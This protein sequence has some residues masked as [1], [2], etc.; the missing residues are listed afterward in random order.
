MANEKSLLATIGGAVKSVF[1]WL[2]ST[3]GQTIITTAEG[4]ATTIFPPAAGIIAI[5]NAGLAEAIKIEAIAAAAGQ[6]NG[7]GVAKSADLVTTLTPA[8]LSYAEQHGF[9]VPTAAKIQA[10]SDSLV[11]FLNALD[12]K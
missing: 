11:A 9:P 1:A 12:G 10:A 3:K 7:S 8:I 2:G 4:A 5:A 6:Q